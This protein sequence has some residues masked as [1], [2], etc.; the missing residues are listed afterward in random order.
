MRLGGQGYLSMAHN[1]G[2]AA[3]SENTASPNMLELVASVP[4]WS[5]SEYYSRY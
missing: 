4:K 1:E 5:V 2:V 3:S